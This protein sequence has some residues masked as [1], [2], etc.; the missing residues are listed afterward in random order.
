MKLLSFLESDFGMKL[1]L[2]F[3][4]DTTHM[5]FANK[6]SKLAFSTPP[7]PPQ[8][9]NKQNKSRALSNELV[10]LDEL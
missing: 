1:M 7:P 4:Y 6:V 5:Y 3:S 9:D 10:Y 8:L 2:F